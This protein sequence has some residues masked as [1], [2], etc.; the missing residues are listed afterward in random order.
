VLKSLSRLLRERLRKTDL[1]G[2]YGGEEF[3]IILLDTTPEAAREILDQIRESFARIRH[4]AED[5]DFYV[6]LSCGLASYP[7]YVNVGDLTEA[8]DRALYDAK[9]S[10]RNRVVSA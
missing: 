3:G 6:T 4:S 7:R 5:R 9:E 8:A 1:I 10:G 2:R